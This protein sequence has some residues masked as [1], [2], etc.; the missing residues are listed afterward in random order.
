MQISEPMRSGWRDRP[1]QGLHAA[2]R[3]AD[4]RGEPGDAEVIGDDPL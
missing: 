1:H 2:E 3:A 4:D